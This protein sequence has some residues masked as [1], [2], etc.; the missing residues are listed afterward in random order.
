[1]TTLLDPIPWLTDSGRLSLEESINPLDFGH[2][3]S[4]SPRVGFE[5]S[6]TAYPLPLDPAPYSAAGMVDW[7]YTE[8]GEL[9]IF[10]PRWGFSRNGSD[11]D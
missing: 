9:I 6:M 1:M 2:R 5:P 3:L 7:R 10:A 8:P 11:Y 4:W